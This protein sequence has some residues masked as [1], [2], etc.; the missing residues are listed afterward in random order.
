MYPQSKKIIYSI[1]SKLNRKNNHPP[2]II[3]G[4]GRS[5][6]TWILELVCSDPRYKMIFDGKKFVDDE[7]TYK[8]TEVYKL[9][10]TIP[11]K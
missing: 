9:N 6:T 5:G 3:A 2:L 4:S 10:I 11:D 7:S 1:Y 8:N